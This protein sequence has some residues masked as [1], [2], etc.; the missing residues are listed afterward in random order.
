MQ[1]FLKCSIRYPSVSDCDTGQIRNKQT[2]DLHFWK[3]IY[4]SPV[5]RH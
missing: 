3:L 2:V 5:T 4:P 1:K